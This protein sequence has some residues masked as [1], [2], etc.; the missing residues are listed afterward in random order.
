MNSEQYKK[1][2]NEN[3]EKY[4][5]LCEKISKSMKG[6]CGILARSYGCKTSAET[7]KKQSDAKKGKHPWNYGLTKENNESV[8]KNSLSTGKTVK[9]KW[10]IDKEYRRKSVKSHKKYRTSEKTKLKMRNS[11]IKNYLKNKLPRQG[12]N[13]KKILDRIEK[14]IGYKLLRQYSIDGYFVDGYCKETNTV[15]EIYENYHKSNK[16]ALK[17]RERRKYIRNKIKCKLIIIKDKIPNTKLFMNKYVLHSLID[18]K[19]FELINEGEF[20]DLKLMSKLPKAVLED[21]YAENWHEILTSN[22]DLNLKD[23]RTRVPKRCLQV[24]KQVMINN[25]LNNEVKNGCC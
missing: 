4:K 8:L 23:I 9:E 18:K 20:L 21:I 10:A 19:I 17:D 16:V 22:M 14:N 5:A 11:A 2:K 12:K 25:Q 24:L 1:W 15:Y 6:K 7:R 13:E 3:P